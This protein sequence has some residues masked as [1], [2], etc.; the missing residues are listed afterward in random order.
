M[1]DGGWRVVVS[2]FTT[3]YPLPATR[4][5]LPATRYPHFPCRAFADIFPGFAY[6]AFAATVT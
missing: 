4:Y 5:P 3:R 1:A 6:A 2:Q